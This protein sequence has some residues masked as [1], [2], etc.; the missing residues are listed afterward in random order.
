MD[1]KEGRKERKKERKKKSVLSFLHQPIP[2]NA[3]DGDE[4]RGESRTGS[5][6]LLPI[7]HNAEDIIDMYM[8][9]EWFETDYISFAQSLINEGL[10]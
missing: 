1:M 8:M 3:S 5:P 10:L 6:I 7:N 9:V 2:K 4:S